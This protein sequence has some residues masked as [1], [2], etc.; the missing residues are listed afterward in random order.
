MQSH[1]SVASKRRRRFQTIGDFRVVRAV[2]GSINSVFET[3]SLF[4]AADQRFRMRNDVSLSL[5]ADRVVWIVV[6]LSLRDDL[7]DEIVDPH[8]CTTI[9]QRGT[10]IRNR[11]RELRDEEVSF[12][13]GTAILR[14]V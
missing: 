5:R 8:S 2:F 3:R 4:L 10:L 14:P 1:A 13:R 12:V 7:V 9:S 6:S 11:E